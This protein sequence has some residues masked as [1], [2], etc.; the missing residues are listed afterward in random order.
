MCR[1][2]YFRKNH[3][4]SS[5]VVLLE[6]IT[7]KL[8]KFMTK[9]AGTRKTSKFRHENRQMTP[10]DEIS[11]AKKTPIQRKERLFK[12]NLAKTTGSEAAKIQ[13]SIEC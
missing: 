9:P 5:P 2:A 12:T 11:V 13:H 8:P 1:A 6:P 10:S 7:W 4:W 3:I